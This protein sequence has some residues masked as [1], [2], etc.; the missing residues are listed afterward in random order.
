MN[1]LHVLM[2]HTQLQY[3]LYMISEFVQIHMDTNYYSLYDLS[4]MLHIY[5]Y[6]VCSYY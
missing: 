5:D 1:L 3:L 4:R 2:S 6:A